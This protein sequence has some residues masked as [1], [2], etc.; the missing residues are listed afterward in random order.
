MH[1][2]GQ[3]KFVENKICFLKVENDI[4]LAHVSIIFVHLL[5]VAV[6]DFE[7]DQ[8]VVGGSTAG[9]EKE[10]CITAIDYFAVWRAHAC[11]LQ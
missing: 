2:S 6:D 5:D 11:Q 9:D 7:G 3:E 8:F 10:G 4:Q 1:F